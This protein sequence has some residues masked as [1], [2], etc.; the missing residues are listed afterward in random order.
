MAVAQMSAV[1]IEQI[2]DGVGTDD[3][4]IA[5]DICTAVIVVGAIRNRRTHTDAELA[6]DRCNR[7]HILATAAAAALRVRLSVLGGEFHSL[8]FLPLIAEPD[9]HHIL[10]E[11]QLFGDGRNFFTGW[12]R[13]DGKVCF[14]RTLFWRCDGSPFS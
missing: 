14:K 11:I 8:L 7:C 4:V 1:R 5:V 3:G 2:V 6:G 10:F 13:L 12:S 9:A